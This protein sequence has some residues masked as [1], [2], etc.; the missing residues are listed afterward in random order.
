M[1]KLTMRKASLLGLVLLG[2]S[3]VTAFVIPSRKDTSNDRQANGKLQLQ[4]VAA[5][6]GAQNTCITASAAQNCNETT[7]HGVGAGS[8]TSAD[9]DESS[10]TADSGNTTANDV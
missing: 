9:G 10:F 6:G 3:A 7:S 1:E 2:A 8:A 5:G 4:S